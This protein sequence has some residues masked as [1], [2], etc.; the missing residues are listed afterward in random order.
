MTSLPALLGSTT[1]GDGLEMIALSIFV[2]GMAGV[3]AYMQR[4]GRRG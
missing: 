3:L 4:G 1:V 2:V